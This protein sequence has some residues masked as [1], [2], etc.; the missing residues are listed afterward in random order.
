VDYCANFEIDI[1]NRFGIGSHLLDFSV[2][3]PP[4]SYLPLTFTKK[5][6]GASNSAINMTIDS[7]VSQQEEF[8]SGSDFIM[9]ID[10]EGA[11]YDLLSNTDIASLAKAKNIIL[12]FHD[13]NDGRVNMLIEKLVSADFA[14]KLYDELIQKEVDNNAD[15]GV[16]FAKRKN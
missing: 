9:Q 10:I 1:L 3:G 15:H 5:F 7:W 14:V 16:I 2:D 11:E 4:G 6:L 13:N 12:E 8:K